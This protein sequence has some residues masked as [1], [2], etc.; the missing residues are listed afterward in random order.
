MYSVLILT[1][2]EE[3]NIGDCIA[4]IRSDDVVVLDS[5][6]TDG[7]REIASAAGARVFERTFDN[8]AAQR[9]A[10]LELPGL[11]YPW[12][13]M[14]D[15]DERVTPELHHEIL[16]RLNCAGADIGMFRMRRQDI[17][18]G[19]WL[20]R[21][22]GYPTWFGRL[23]RLGAVHVERE[24]NEEFCTSLRVGE[25][26]HHIVHYPFNR[27][28]PYW[29]ERHNRYSTMEA[30]VLAGERSRPIVWGALV[31]RDPVARRKAAKQLIYRVPM[32]PMLVFLYLYL[33]RAG[34]RD[35]LPGFLFCRMRA[36]YETMIDIKAT[37]SR[38]EHRATRSKPFP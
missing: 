19:R 10:A 11:R 4:S 18:L 16:D 27:G 17:F 36:V 8:Y 20:R 25:L 26:H 15:A 22:S 1:R 23:L 33:I 24:I 34:F 21:S 30:V 9:N 31:S 13:L 2:D 37:A 29:F 28:L 5:H 6:S 12:V 32:R 35:G 14:L 38:A 3:L 7:T